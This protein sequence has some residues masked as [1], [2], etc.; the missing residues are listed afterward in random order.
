MLTSE[1][2][3]Y[4]R[5]LEI[6]V[7]IILDD[8][9]N[10]CNYKIKYLHIYLYLHISHQKGLEID[11]H[12]IDQWFSNFF[13]YSTLFQY[14]NMLLYIFSFLHKRVFKVMFINILQNIIYTTI[15]SNSPFV[16]VW[17]VSCNPCICAC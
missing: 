10:V 17:S 13:D 15:F 7:K 6:G 2:Q 1:K 12:V 14:A 3:G 9:R 16:I 11:K 4:R 8:K 5:V